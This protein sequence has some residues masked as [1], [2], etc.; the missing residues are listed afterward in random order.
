MNLLILSFLIIVEP[1][2]LTNSLPTDAEAPSNDPDFICDKSTGEFAPN[3]V[4]AQKMEQCSKQDENRPECGYFC[5]AK[6][7]G[8]LGEDG[9]PSKEAY[10]TW[11]RKTFPVNLQPKVIKYLLNCIDQHPV[12]LDD[13][14]CEGAAKL[15]S[16]VW[17]LA[18]EISCE[19]LPS[20]SNN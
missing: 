1:F 17:S 10:T 2:L 6:I 9:L 15:N 3:A 20:S 16:C 5:M 12:D 4:V 7:F 8:H 18:P 13:K 14:T 19:K 11:V